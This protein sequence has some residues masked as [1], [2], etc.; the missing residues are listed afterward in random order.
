MNPHCTHFPAA[1]RR[2][3][4]VVLS[5]GRAG[6]SLLTQVLGSLGVGLSREL[7]AGRQDNPDG[8]FE[9][10]RIVRIQ[11]N[12]LRNLAAWPY[13]P[14]PQGWLDAPAT[15]EAGRE[16]QTLMRAWLEDVRA[17]PGFKDPRTASFL[18]LWRRLFA[19]VG[20]EPIYLLALRDPASVIQSFQRAYAT[21]PEIAERVWLQRT[22]D[23]L[24]HTD[25]ACHIVHYEAW[26]S[27][28]ER[29]AAGL[30]FSLG[31][32][33]PPGEVLRRIVKPELARARGD[34]QGLT[35]EPA[36]ALRAALAGC[37][38]GDF[39]RA[40]LLRIVSDGLA[41]LETDPTWSRTTG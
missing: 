1:P 21:P 35:L 37:Q 22:C 8:F 6:S 41:A 10:A 5:S 15:A 3:I 31:L 13:Y 9:D 28:P 34:G 14:P 29:V 2:K 11:A 16:L 30:A 12:L 33:P 40:G 27:H 4:A 26:F 23:A 36:R 25:A 32:P 20:V 24:R 18:P 38:G 17:L 7:I 19:E 39:D